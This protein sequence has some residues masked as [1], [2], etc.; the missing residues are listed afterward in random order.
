MKEIKLILILKKLNG[1]TNDMPNSSQETQSHLLIH[2]GVEVV[3][4]LLTDSFY[5][6][7][8][9]LLNCIAYIS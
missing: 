2:L 4:I 9:K 7:M 1:Q 5:Q 3:V 8:E 6:V